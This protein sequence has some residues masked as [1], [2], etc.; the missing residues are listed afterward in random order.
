MTTDKMSHMGASTQASSA[1]GSNVAA[2]L[3]S[4]RFFAEHKIIL[5]DYGRMIN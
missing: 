4:S 5:T 3:K 1:V 2:M